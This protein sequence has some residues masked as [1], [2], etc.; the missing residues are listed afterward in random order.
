MP[1]ISVL[2]KPASGLC[3]MQCRYCFYSDEM[4]RRQV[5]FRG[6]M[7]IE[8]MKRLVDRTLAFAERYCMF[9]FQG[10]EPSLAGLDFFQK[11]TDYVN[12]H[13][14]AKQMQIEYSFQTNGYHLD[15]AW[16]QWF[17]KN[18]VL[19]GVSLDGPEEIHDRYRVTQDGSGTF[20]NVMETIHLLKE[21]QIEYNILTVVTAESASRGKELYAYFKEQQFHFQQ[22]IECL[23]PIGEPPGQQ[24]Y[25]LTPEAY[26]RFLKDTFDVWYKDM[27]RGNYTYHRY[28]ENL[29]LILA[30]RTPESCNMRGVCGAQWVI[31][32]DGSVYPCDFYVLDEWCIGNICEDPFDAME[33]KRQEL[34]F[35]E[36]SRKLPKECRACRYV[37]L[38]RNGC[39]RNREPVTEE[40]TQK[41]YFCTAY[42]GFL[43]YA[44]PRLTEILRL[45]S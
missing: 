33:V 43:D 24:E 25:S 11:F 15:E 45:L 41:N 36:W 8:T 18:H 14:R 27:K 39:R 20:R 2:I 31:E 3:N 38:C 22:Y 1:P 30:G 19:V 28:F 40:V 16:M 32:A 12:R 6:I 9:S 5:P 42:R 10:G 7:S 17:K 34:G 29:M 26:E 21:Y 13:P 44:Y 23:D 35:I 4:A 37:M